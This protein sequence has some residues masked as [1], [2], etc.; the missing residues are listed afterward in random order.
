MKTN[1]EHEE[2][3]PEE[4]KAVAIVGLVCVIVIITFLAI[5]SLYSFLC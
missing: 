2:M 3:T 1:E 4:S 5:V